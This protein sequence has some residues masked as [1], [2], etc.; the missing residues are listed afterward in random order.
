[1]NGHE[2]VTYTLAIETVNRLADAVERVILS[3]E[4]APNQPGRHT[5]TGETLTALNNAFGLFWA[6]IDYPDIG[7]RNDRCGAAESLSGAGQCH[8][9]PAGNRYGGGERRPTA[10]GP[11]EPCTGTLYGQ[12]CTG[13]LTV[14]WAFNPTGG[15]GC[16]TCG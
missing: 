3:A 7:T 14:R 5:V 8:R 9:D 12:P 4:K 11:N 10:R 13:V 2:R 15:K 16:H 1:M 6:K